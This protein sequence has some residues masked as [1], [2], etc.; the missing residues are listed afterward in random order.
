MSELSSAIALCDR[1][2]NAS[3]RGFR[4]AANLPRHGPLPPYEGFAAGFEPVPNAWQARLFR[5]VMNRV[6]QFD[7]VTLPTGPIEARQ[8]T[9]SR[10]TIWGWL[11]MIGAVV[12]FAPTYRNDLGVW[13]LISFTYLY[14]VFAF[15]EV[16]YRYFA[17]VWPV[18]LILMVLPLDWIFRQSQEWR[19]RSEIPLG[20]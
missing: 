14:R 7:L 10:P 20:A 1:V 2:A 15:S 19:L 8:I 13:T 4:L 9:K 18:L 17:P 3:L 11:V 12:S 16:N 5:S 6:G